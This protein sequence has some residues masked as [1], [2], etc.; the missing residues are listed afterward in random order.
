[1]AL[2]LSVLDQFLYTLITRMRPTTSLG[3]IGLLTTTLVALL[4]LAFANRAIG[5]WLR[6][7][8]PA[9]K[10]HPTLI[11]A[12][13]A[14]PVLVGLAPYV[15]YAASPHWRLRGRFVTGVFKG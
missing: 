6:N 10:A 12:G 4:L 1:M 8:V 2:A 15:C 14:V 9:T 3:G 5:R 7:P 13:P 11:D